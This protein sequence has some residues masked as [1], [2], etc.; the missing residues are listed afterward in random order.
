MT[1]MFGVLTFKAGYEHIVNVP[2]EEFDRRIREWFENNPRYNEYLLIMEY[3]SKGDNPHLNVIVDTVKE[4]QRTTY[5]KKLI[6]E[7]VYQA[8]LAEVTKNNKY[9]AS[10]ELVKDLHHI[11][12]YLLKE[13]GKIAR[14]RLIG[15]RGNT[16]SGYLGTTEEEFALLL[17][18]YHKEYDEYLKNKGKQAEKEFC[19]PVGKNGMW[20]MLL[21]ERQKKFNEDGNT[22]SYDEF[23]EWVDQ[24]MLN[25][26]VVF[27]EFL[28]KPRMI[29]VMIERMY[30]ALDEYMKYGV[31]QAKNELRDK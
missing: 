16:L 8:P 9:R 28:S 30:G 4:F 5:D 3:G 27:T 13:I 21:E 18:G 23:L 14:S 31:I 29:Y 17:D 12:I 24:V 20:S 2:D 15:W 19:D 6:C 1:W 11:L 7:F 25:N 26:K 22:M 10:F